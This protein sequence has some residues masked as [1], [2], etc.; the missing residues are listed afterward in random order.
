MGDFVEIS[1]VDLEGSRQFLRRFVVS[2][3]KSEKLCC[4]SIKILWNRTSLLFTSISI[5]T[6]V[7]EYIMSESILG[8]DF[9]IMTVQKE[10]HRIS[11]GLSAVSNSSTHDASTI[12]TLT[13]QV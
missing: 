5:Y 12:N 3:E 6:A 10:F 4:L 8:E 9:I 2:H 13:E 7:S 1:N 11:C